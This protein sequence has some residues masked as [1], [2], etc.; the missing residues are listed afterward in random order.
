MDFRQ[1]LIFAFFFCGR[2]NGWVNLKRKNCLSPDSQWT[3]FPSSDEFQ[4]L[5][6]II[7]GSVRFL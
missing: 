1:T 5:I 2:E 7:S 3:S 6:Q 4:S